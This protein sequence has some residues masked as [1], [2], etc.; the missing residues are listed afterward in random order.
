MERGDGRIK[1][2]NLEYGAKTKGQKPVGRWVFNLKYKADGTLKTYKARLV[3]KGYTQIYRILLE[4]ICSSKND[5]YRFC[6]PWLHV[7]DWICNHLM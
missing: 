1:E 2:Q 4:N 7:L 6:Y 5:H 3:A